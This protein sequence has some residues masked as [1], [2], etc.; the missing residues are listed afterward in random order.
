MALHI[1]LIRELNLF[2]RQRQMFSAKHKNKNL[3]KYVICNKSNKNRKIV[4]C[5]VTMLKSKYVCGIKGRLLCSL[6]VQEDTLL[7]KYIT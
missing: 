3:H 1:I 5:T 2:F 7:K 6:I 4:I